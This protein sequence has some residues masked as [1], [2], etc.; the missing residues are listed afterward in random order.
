MKKST[1]ITILLQFA[2]TPI[3]SEAQTISLG[4]PVPAAQR[5]PMDQFDHSQWNNLLKKFVYEGG[6]TRMA[7]TSC[8]LFL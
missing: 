3:Q 6:L 7:L 8:K 4:Q 2:L 5:I 1:A